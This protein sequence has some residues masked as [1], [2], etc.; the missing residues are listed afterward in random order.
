MLRD[1]LSHRLGCSD[2]LLASD[3]LLYQAVVLVLNSIMLKQ[4]KKF[5]ARNLS[6]GKKQVYYL[7]MEFLLGRSLRN[8]LFN[9]GLIEEMETALNKLDSVQKRSLEHLYPLEPDAGL[10]NGGLGRLAACYLDALAHEEYL[11]T[12]YC[13]LYEFGIFKQSILDG[14]QYEE[15]DNWLPGGEVWLT[16]KPSYEVEVKFGGNIEETWENG[17]HVLQHK[18][19]SSVRALAYD[20]NLPGY[21]S[22]GISLLRVWRA[23]AQSGMDMDAFNQ[24]DYTTAFQQKAASEAISKVL[25][26]NDN[27]IEGK[28]L[29]LRQQYFLCAASIS[30]IC[31]RHLSNYGTLDN[32]AEKNAIHINDTHPTLAIPELMRFLVD[33]CG[34][35]W[36]QAWDIVYK[37]FAY[38]NHT[39]MAEALERW[40]E[41]LL[42]NLLPRIY[43]I[44]CEINRRFC[45]H[46]F[47]DLHLNQDAVSRMSIV[48][49]HQIRMANLAVVGSHCVN[50]VSALHSQILRDDVFKDFYSVFP[51][52][53]TNVTNGIASRRWLMQAN[54]SLTG[55][56]ADSIGKH[57]GADMMNL[58][59]LNDFAD[60]AAFLDKLAASK[61]E[62]KERFCRYV[63]RKTGVLLNPDSIFD[64]QVKRLHEYKRQQMNALDILA[65]YQY[66]RDN[67]NA[68]FTP[69]TYIFGAKAAPGY[70]IAKQVIKLICSLAD[71]IESDPVIRE[72]MRVVFLEE[73]NVTLS[74]LLMPASDI[75]EQISLA[76]YEAS[77]TGNMKLMLNGAVTL[78]TMDGANVEIYE[79]VGADNIIIFGLTAEEVE[80]KK[81]NG[82]DPM[83]FYRS[84]PVIRQ[85]VEAL[86]SNL[87]GQSFPELYQ[88]LKTSDPYLTLADFD[89]Y[90][91]ARARSEELYNERYGWLKMSLKNIAESGVFCADRSVNEYARGIW[92]L[93]K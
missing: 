1:T 93:E 78:G 89:A 18:N 81:R 43:M 61:R 70:Y 20:I 9:M 92:G 45:A 32:F 55:L 80:Q 67:P 42:K 13:I 83:H 47:E 11:A 8:S 36:G 59:K 15:P 52:K 14:W 2:P 53:F 25:Y 41:S 23:K 87:L 31:R 40:D 21:N 17:H 69:R 84:N 12:G 49:G 51:E 60:D 54:P 64:V 24:G 68:E 88:L 77:G 79:A 44:I 66:L 28:T 34:Y 76:G 86:N 7:S 26:P 48:F 6:M 4:R 65:T 38:T 58:Q 33:D 91:A 74:E 35:P 16:S 75:S 71:K 39:V 37:T 57:F 56:I 30:D 50:G 62:N 46:L 82:Y 10:G 29:R 85:A 5:W 3:E 19:H 90:R 27:H 73:Y 63:E 72:K 22:D